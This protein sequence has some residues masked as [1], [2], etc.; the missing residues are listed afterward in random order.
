[1]NDL[2]PPELCRGT[3]AHQ[4]EELRGALSLFM[5]P[6]VQTIESLLH[7]FMGGAAV[8]PAAVQQ[9]HWCGEPV[10]RPRKGS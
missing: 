2:L 3:L 8:K 10:P 7:R 9:C 1:M 5:S 6:A 4:Q